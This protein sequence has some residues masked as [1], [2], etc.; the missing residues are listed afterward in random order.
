[1]FL[2]R[3]Y[4]VINSSLLSIYEVL[5]MSTMSQSVACSYGVPK[6]PPCS[7]LAVTSI[8]YLVRIM[9]AAEPGQPRA[10]RCRPQHTYVPDYQQ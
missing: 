7:V 3:N 5:R 9:C 8:V 1:M 2:P 10:H 4:G 6:T